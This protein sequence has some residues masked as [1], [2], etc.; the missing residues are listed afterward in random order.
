MCRRGVKFIHNK[1]GL[2]SYMELYAL[3]KP[4]LLAQVGQILPDSV[5]SC[6]CAHHHNRRKVED[7][8]F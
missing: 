4:G 3:D 5:F 7:I 8:L 1:R 6:R 2:R